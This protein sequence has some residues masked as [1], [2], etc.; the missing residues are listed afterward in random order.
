[1]TRVITFVT[2]NKNKLRE[3]QTILGASPSGSWSLDSKSLDGLNRLLAGFDDKSATAICTFAYCEGPGSEPILFEG[4]TLGRIVP[5][6]G[7]T[8]FGWD[9]VFEVE[10][11]GKTYVHCRLTPSFADM[12]ASEKNAVCLPC[13]H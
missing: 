2:G 5:P 13:S 10:G 3:V 8:N 12:D 1:M 9:P 11:S 7:P 6:R 4:K